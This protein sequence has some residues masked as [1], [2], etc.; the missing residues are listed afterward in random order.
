MLNTR[1]DHLTAAYTL[2]HYKLFIETD[3]ESQKLLHV[4]KR[5]Q[6]TSTTDLNSKGLLFSKRYF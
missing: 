3:I 4:N 1:F 5:Y 2:K 6:Q